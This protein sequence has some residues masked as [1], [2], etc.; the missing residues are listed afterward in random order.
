MSDLDKKKYDVVVV[1]GGAAGLM[2][3]ATAGKN[4]K[5]VVLIEHTSKIG[6]KIRISGG[7]RC[8]FTNL[9]ASPQNY[10]CE[11]RHFVKSS[12]TQYSQYDFINLVESYGIAYHEKKL[13]QLF[14]DGSSKQIIKMLLDECSL[15]KV[16]ILINCS[17]EF[18]EKDDL[19]LLKTNQGLIETKSLIIATGG[20]SIPQIGA[21]DFGYN[22]A[23]QF[24]INVLETRPALVPLM[25][26]SESL[27]FFTKLSGISQDSI[28]SYEDVNFREN[29]LF[30]HRGISGPA[31]LQISS[32]LKKFNME[33]IFINLLPD[34][35]LKKEFIANKNS[36]QTIGQFLKNHF[37]NRLIETL[38]LQLDFNKS[39]NSLNKNSLF[40]IADKLHGFRVYIRDSEGYQKAEVT[41]GGVDTEE[42]SSKTM[43]SHKV[44]NLFFV[45]EVVDVTGWLGGYN[46]QWAWSSGYAAGQYC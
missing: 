23:K 7:G 12:L 38:G 8:N 39:I 3:A 32:Y 41:S 5:N 36:K 37:Q 34:F 20:L 2:A 30:T 4:G 10:I 27:D 17:V 44:P 26:N 35:D 43:E 29:I 46:F 42:L 33:E 22:V 14:C 11:N 31:I 9:Y 1:G 15:G 13:G 21:T 19:F 25:V 24:D 6:E 28:V 45:G 16:N 18:I 40:A